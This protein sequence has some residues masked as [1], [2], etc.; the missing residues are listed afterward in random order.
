MNLLK[1]LIFTM[2]VPGTVIILIPRWLLATEH[3]EPI[4]A[5]RFVGLIPLAIGVA[6]YLWCA[7][8]FATAGKG[9]PV[10]FDPPKRL[11]VRG[12]YKFVRNPMYVGILSILFGE[13]LLFTSAYLFGYA[14]LVTTIFHSF[15]VLYE[16]P[17]LGKKF[18]DE[19]RH[20]RARVPRWLPSLSNR[21]EKSAQ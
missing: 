18:G 15:V 13:A 10:V 1:T 3:S 14:V 8:D 5:F 6:I 2:L 20:Y 19:Y 9:T 21:A 17:A 4:G 12:L 16:E 11:V 7:W